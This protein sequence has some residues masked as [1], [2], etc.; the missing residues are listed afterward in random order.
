MCG[1]KSLFFYH[2]QL[3][4]VLFYFKQNFLDAKTDEYHILMDLNVLAP[5]ICIREA[6][7]LMRKHKNEGHIININR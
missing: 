2:H 4:I 1:L 3:L 5:A 7:K 6:L